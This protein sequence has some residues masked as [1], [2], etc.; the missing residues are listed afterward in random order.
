MSSSTQPDGC[1]TAAT[2]EGGYVVDGGTLALTGAT[3]RE[4]LAAVLE[5]RAA[6]RFIARGHS[7]SPFIRDG[8]AITVSPCPPRQ[9][10]VG[11]VAACRSTAGD[12]LF[13]HRVVGRSGPG[14]LVRGDNAPT[15]DGPVAADDVLGIVTLVERRGRVVHAA[16]GPSARLVAALSRCG[17][18][19]PCVN[20]GRRVVRPLIRRGGE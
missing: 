8:D 6:F 7:M 20:A 18:L 5:R 10:R 12:G 16:V 19:R 9:L 2:G 13:V 1:A 17:C 15:A 14:Y 3:L 4:F 11:E